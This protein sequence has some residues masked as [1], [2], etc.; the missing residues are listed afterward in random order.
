MP[1]TALEIARENASFEL[2]QSLRVLPSRDAA[3]VPLLL[4]EI[5]LRYHVLGIVTLLTDAVPDTFAAYL[6]L[7]GQTDA[8]LRS[9]NLSAHPKY[10]A[11]SRGVPFLDALTAGDLTSARSIA[12]SAPTTHD[13][14][15]EYEDDFLKFR[16][17]HVLTL[18]P[19]ADDAVQPI[20]TRWTVV[21]EGAASAAFDVA[22]AITNRDEKALD[23][24]L[25]L[26]L[27]ERRRTLEAWQATPA[28]REEIAATESA[29]YVE[30]LGLLRIAELRGLRADREYDMMPSIAR[31]PLSTALPP[32]GAWRSGTL[33]PSSP[34]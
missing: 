2:E 25:E 12:A 27:A 6:S 9:L 22:Q 21:L 23:E 8:Q 24:S 20:L 16:F 31:I 26:L 19:Q 30:G 34:L 29:I 18:D 5:A 14:D 10:L 13:P 17:M 1:V 28:Y 3:G 33:T 32:P 4:G 11:G 15:W 7:S